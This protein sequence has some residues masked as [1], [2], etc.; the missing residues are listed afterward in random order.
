MFIINPYIFEDTAW[1]PADLPNILT[2]H[3]A[4]DESTFSYLSG[5]V[6]QWRD[7][8]G[9]NNTFQQAASSKRPFRQG[10]LNGLPLV[11]Y[12]GTDKY[13]QLGTRLTNVRTACILCKW[14]DT[15]GDY[16]FIF[17]DSLA[18]NTYDYH[19]NTA[20]SNKLIGTGVSSNVTGGDLWVDGVSTDPSLAPRYTDWTQHIFANSGDTTIGNFSAD[21]DN[22]YGSRSFKGQVAEIVLVSGVMTEADRLALG[23]YWTEK[24]GL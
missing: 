22:T 24:W 1:S 16:R 7:K 4:A 3:D 10:T 14:T 20:A 6:Y 23:A 8:S 13:L 5:A 15:T 11:E 2:W 12:N 19:G 17:G 18:G 21:R 9:N